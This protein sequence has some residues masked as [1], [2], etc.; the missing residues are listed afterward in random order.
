MG[1]DWGGAGIKIKHKFSALCST[2]SYNDDLRR[3]AVT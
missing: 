2:F 3:N 1:L